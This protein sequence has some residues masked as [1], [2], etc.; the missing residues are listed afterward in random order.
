MSNFKF[1]VG[2]KVKYKDR[3]F[4]IKERLPLPERYLLDDFTWYDVDKLSPLKVKKKKHVPSRESCTDKIERQNR[5]RL[6]SARRY[7]EGKLQW[8]LVDFKSLEGLVRVLE[9][10]AFKYSLFETTIDEEFGLAGAPVQISGAELLKRHNGDLKEAQITA[11]EMKLISSGRDNWKNGL[12]NTEI[13]ESAMRHLIAMLDGE[14]LDPESGL[15]H[16]DHLLCNIMFY[17]FN[18]RR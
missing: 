12:D 6:N 15:P 18:K 17:N 16:S 7:N 11:M 10:G 2:Q 1:K 9:F 4:T 8:S 3:V 14:E 13:L 5:E